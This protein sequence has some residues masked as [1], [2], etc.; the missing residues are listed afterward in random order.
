M[1][2]FGI[3]SQILDTIVIRASVFA[4]ENGSWLVLKSISG[5]FYILLPKT[6]KTPS[7]KVVTITEDEYNRLKLLSNGVVSEKWEVIES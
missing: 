4:I 7:P 5:M 3:I 6:I 1:V 2:V